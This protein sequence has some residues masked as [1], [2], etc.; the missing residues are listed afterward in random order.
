[1]AAAQHFQATEPDDLEILDQLEAIVLQQLAMLQ[2]GR[3]LDLDRPNLHRAHPGATPPPGTN[4]RAVGDDSP[5]DAAFSLA[6]YHKWLLDK[7]RDRGPVARLRAIAEATLDYE[8]SIKRRPAYIDA[9]PD[10]NSRNRDEAIL[11]WEGK[12]AEEVAVFERC[13]FSYVRK[14]RRK[15]G[16]DPRTGRRLEDIDIGQTT[17]DDGGWA[18][19][20]KR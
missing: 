6:E 2:E 13:S 19:E 20:P 3:T 8:T 10:V 5:P 11:R 12:R 9:D 14:L 15:E 16:L 7:A 4:L 18:T 1:M 17:D